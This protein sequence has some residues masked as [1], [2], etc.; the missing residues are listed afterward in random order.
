MVS[1]STKMFWLYIATVSCILCS[2]IDL[3]SCKSNGGISN[4]IVDEH[5]FWMLN[6]DEPETVYNFDDSNILL[7]QTCH[8]SHIIACTIRISKVL[9]KLFK[10]FTSLI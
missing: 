4:A 8:G 2:S 6:A 5:V 1:N 3:T 7:D 9:S 10:T